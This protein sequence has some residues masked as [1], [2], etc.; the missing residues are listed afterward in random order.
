MYLLTAFLLGFLGSLHCVG[1]CG[2]IALALPIRDHSIVSKIS[3]ALLY[4]MGR[5][6]TYTCFGLL[7]G[8]FGRGLALAGMQQTLSLF[9]G[10]VIILFVLAPRLIGNKLGI[11]PFLSRAT[12]KIKNTFSQFFKTKSHSALFMI[13]VLNGLL[14]CGL[15]YAAVLG[16]LSTG[17]VYTGS[18]FM[19]LFGL[20]TV[21]L[22]F[23]VAISKSI[24]SLQIRSRFQRIFPILAMTLGIL[25]FVRGLNLGIPYVSPKMSVE[26]A[27]HRC[28]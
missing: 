8:L 1:M 3:S 18:A 23:L 14:P 11:P 17:S 7:F 28:H 22:M 15:V 5:I 2:P 6:L 9:T 4:N 24:I 27:V 26:G 16:A 21:P 13:G 10:A 20:G 19:A 25:I 12:S